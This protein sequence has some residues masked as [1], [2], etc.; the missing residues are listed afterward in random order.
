MN[1][2]DGP[3]LKVM[4]GFVLLVA[5]AVAGLQIVA[6]SREPPTASVLGPPPSKGLT[7]S[8]LSRMGVH[9]ALDDESLHLLSTATRFELRLSR[10]EKRSR[11]QRRRL[12][13]FIRRTADCACIPAGVSMDLVTEEESL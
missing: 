13:R 7:A 9:I 10:L 12:S 2:Q 3:E 6:M 5:A 1:R 11:R 4:I 8:D